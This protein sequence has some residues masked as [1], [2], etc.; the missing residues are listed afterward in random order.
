MRVG[1]LSDMSR[2]RFSI[3]DGPLNATF[4][5]AGLSCQ[6]VITQEITMDAGRQVTGQTTE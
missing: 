2:L 6:F 3:G 1:F 4:L 5:G